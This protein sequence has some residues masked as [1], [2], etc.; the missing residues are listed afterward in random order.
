MKKSLTLLFISIVAYFGPVI[1][2]SILLFAIVASVFGE[3]LL[4]DPANGFKTTPL[5]FFVIGLPYAVLAFFG[6]LSIVSIIAEKLTNGKKLILLHLI[7]WYDKRHIPWS[8]IAVVTGALLLVTAFFPL[9]SEEVVGANIGA[10]IQ[11]AFGGLFM[12]IGLYS[13]YW[14]KI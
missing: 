4:E 6:L 5:G 11:A 10:G 1:V 8:T 9:S 2:A 3:S 12:F 13:K 7:A 14:S